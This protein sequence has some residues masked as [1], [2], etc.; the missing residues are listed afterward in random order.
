MKR[1]FLLIVV[2]IF[3]FLSACQSKDIPE[4][5]HQE[6]KSEETNSENS[7]LKPSLPNRYIGVR[8]LAQLNEM[9]AMIVEKNE[10][11]LAQYLRSVEG[12]GARTRDDL[13]TFIDLVDSLPIIKLIDGDITW[14]AYYHNDNTSDK[15]ENGIVHISTRSKK[16]EW[17]RIEYKLLETDINTE[18]E[19]MQ[20]NEK[21][22]NG[23]KGE[24]F[25]SNDDR[26]KV[27]YQ[28]MQ[29]HPSGSG[30]IYKWIASVDDIIIHVVY[31]TSNSKEITAFDFF[32]GIEITRLRN[33]N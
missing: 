14:I 10:D 6:T 7:V 23:K 18:I 17:T 29:K 15:K 20:F 13:I 8:S 21:N 24:L 12:G 30:N 27:H 22:L 19:A 25:K 5:K 31:S 4:M 3:V 11:N 32:K 2:V 26:I 28:T 16:D 1:I 9:R 33:Y